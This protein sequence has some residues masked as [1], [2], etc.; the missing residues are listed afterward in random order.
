MNWSLEANIR[1]EITA[2]LRFRP[3]LLNTFD[4]ANDDKQK[5]STSKTPK[6]PGVGYGLFEYAFPCPRSWHF[7]SKRFDAG[8]V[9]PSFEVV[10]GA[11]GSGA[12]SE[13]VGFLK[14]IDKLPQIDTILMDPAK[15]KVPD[16]PAALYAVA[17]ALSR[18]ATDLNI[19]RIC[20]YIERIPAEFS[21]V[22]MRNIIK[23][24]SK[25]VQTKAF[26]EWCIKHS[27]VM[28]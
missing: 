1:P 18:R 3:R 7:L 6:T 28:K 26:N 13:F 17:E 15:S 9:H 25:L 4:D 22:C 20:T 5:N 21:V 2:F 12:A 14:L 11:V 24:N 19:G 23:I 10:C 27:F 8:K 16:D